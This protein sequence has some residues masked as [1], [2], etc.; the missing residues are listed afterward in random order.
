METPK[1]FCYSDSLI[2]DRKNAEIVN[3]RNRYALANRRA[4]DAKALLTTLR[5]SEARLRDLLVHAKS[6]LT[7]APKDCFGVAGDGAS[8]WYLV[9]ELVS[10]IDAAL[11]QRDGD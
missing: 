5:Q 7:N 1:P 11:E 6:A 8:Q 9:D 3:L 10:R 4:N 2:I